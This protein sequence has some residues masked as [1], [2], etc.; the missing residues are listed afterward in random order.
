MHTN[1]A[2]NNVYELPSLTEVIQYYH[3]MAGFP[4]TVTW[5]KVINAGYFATWPMLTAKAAAAK[6]F[7][8]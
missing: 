2:I 6:H 4:T 8:E 5:L 1:E 7:P 3:A